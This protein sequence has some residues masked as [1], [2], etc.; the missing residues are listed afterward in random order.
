MYNG[1]QYSEYLGLMYCG[2]LRVLAAFRGSVQRILPD[3][4]Y[5]GV[6]YCGYSRY[7]KYFRV[8]YCG[9]CTYW[10]RCVRWYCK[11]SEYSE[12]A[13]CTQEYEA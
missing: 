11:Y 4:Q 13:P 12:Y 9:Y 1:I 8:L 2:I 3:T 6:R 7:F 5:F 10:S